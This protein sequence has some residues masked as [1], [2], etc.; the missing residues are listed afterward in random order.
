VGG[1]LIVFVG[2]GASDKGNVWLFPFLVLFASFGTASCF[3]FVFMAHSQLFPTLFSATAIGICNF[4][5]RF[6][7]I[8]AP[9]VA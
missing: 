2:Y 1:W 5:A 4:V 6:A 9:E 7:T 3:N 8:F